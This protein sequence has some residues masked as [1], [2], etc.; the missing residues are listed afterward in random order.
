MLQFSVTPTSI[1]K[2]KCDVSGR[3]F[4]MIP[5]SMCDTIGAGYEVRIYYSAPAPYSHLE[6][7][8]SFEGVPVD[9]DGFTGVRIPGSQEFFC[10]EPCLNLWILSNE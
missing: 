7:S 4:S 10:S 5:C 6:Y 1:L 8:L 3:Y 2:T 9:Y